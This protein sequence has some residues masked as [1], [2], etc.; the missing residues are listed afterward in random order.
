M[1]KSFSFL[2]VDGPRFDFERNKVVLGL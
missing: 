2:F 1:P